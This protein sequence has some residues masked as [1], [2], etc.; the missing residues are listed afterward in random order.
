MKTILNLSYIAIACLCL[1]SCKKNNTD[2]SN[3][4]DTVAPPLTIISET[5]EAGDAIE[6]LAYPYCFFSKMKDSSYTI[7]YN[8]NVGG[9]GF[10][11][12]NYS[13]NG[14]LNWHKQY[15]NYEFA[16]ATCLSFDTTS[17]GGYVICLH[18]Q[19]YSSFYPWTKIMMLNHQGDSLWTKNF[20]NCN[21]AKTI[22]LNNGEICLAYIKNNRPYALFLNSYGDSLRSSY[23]ADTIAGDGTY[24]SIDSRLTSNNNLI[25]FINYTESAF[26]NLGPVITCLIKTD[27]QGNIIWGK[28]IS[29]GLTDVNMNTDGSMLCA[30]G[31]ILNMS[32][33]GEITNVINSQLDGGAVVRM[34]DGNYLFGSGKLF[35]VD[36]LGNVLWSQNFL[37]DMSGHTIKC[38]KLINNN[39]GTYTMFG[40]YGINDYWTAIVIRFTI[41]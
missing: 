32:S 21:F 22:P 40:Y 9:F 1:L 6:Y 8:N 4:P 26:P 7:V 25:F 38:H 24:F 19:E 34:D 16:N 14:I 10:H 37:L 35:K 30:N 20:Y 5:I 12:V 27:P 39:D 17:G 28:K 41:G 23:I 18:D 29:Y 11:V 3:T 31:N 2:D 36:A 33:T 13:W 15:T